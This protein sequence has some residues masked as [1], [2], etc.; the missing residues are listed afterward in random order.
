MS[1]LRN[2]RKNRIV[3][4]MK[5][6]AYKPLL[7][8]ELVTVLDVPA[9]DI[10]DFEEVIKE[11][12]EEGK[13][14]KT[15][16]DRY[17]V[18]ER[19][20]LIT[21]RLQG[22]DRGFGFVIP[23]EEEAGDV[24][25]SGDSLHGAMHNDRV[26]ARINKSNTG[27]KRAEGEV[28]K[29]LKRANTSIVG[30]FESSKYFGFVIPD[31][32]RITSDIFIPKDEINGAKSGEKVVVELIKWPEQRRNAEGRIIEIIG[33]KDDPGN[34]ILSIIK[35]HN[36]AQQ[37][38][39]A[40]LNQAENI[41][42]TVTEDMIKG[43]RD[44]RGLRMVTIDGED[45][46]DLDDAVSVERLP[47]GNYRL[48]VHIADVSYYVTENSP[49]DKEAVKRGTS[50]YL[51][52]RVIPMLPKKLSNG[53]C[54]LNPQVDRLAFS[55][56]MD[57]DKQGRIINH[58]IFESVI[59][60]DE[61]MTYT[62][63][64]KIL[65]EKNP[66]LY[67]RYDYLIS[68]FELM[69][70]L[71]LIL[72]KKRFSRG[73][74]DF[75]F[76][77]A[78]IIL[79]EKGEPIDIKKYEYT[80]ANKIIEEFM[81]ICN[82]TVAEHFYWANAPFVYRIHEEPDIEKI[83]S[84]SDFINK[85]GYHLK[86]S[87]QVHPKAYQDLLSK[88]KGT[89]EERIISTVM[90]RSLQ[91]A[92][93]SHE[94]DGH[95]GLAAKFYCHFTSP[96]RRYPDL[97]IHRIMKEYLRGK[98]NENREDE[99]N[100]RLP[101]IARRCSERERAAEEAERETEDLKKVEYMKQHEGKVFEGI[102]SSVTSFGMF[103]ELDN[104]IEGLVRMSSM[105]DDYYVFDEEQY[106]LFGERNRKIYRIG[107]IVQVQLAKADIAKR[108]LEFVLASDEDNDDFTGYNKSKGNHK[109]GKQRSRDAVENLSEA[110]IAEN[111]HETDDTDSSEK[112]DKRPRKWDKVGHKVRMNIKGRKVR[113]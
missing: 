45:A 76:D 11:L 58:E 36:L 107:D 44:L 79:N 22:S 40:A 78:K 68:N 90:L 96:I 112:K 43:R 91:K 94:S 97:I 47:E 35:A 48:G 80:I 34:D 17:G 59:N 73:A 93:Y 62:N 61:R 106:L 53:I 74:I 8:K 103:I 1:E 87:G 99:L 71:A 13:I 84:F 101:D 7:F 23:D 31:D 108:Q 6:D 57:I 50:V 92:R 30:T 105:E 15:R 27:G 110:V 10:S 72:R 12:E 29:I 67:Q 75:D 95:F 82:E 20:S 54:S 41:S 52:D 3:L 19:M 39:E 100:E 2:E 81:L 32:R 64:Y 37:F 70:E 18:P 98:L 56:F 89:K 14:Y 86:G 33:H 104:T 55:V 60:I 51:V 109:K 111:I 49:L 5:E 24:F 63:V 38:D 25:I 88:V 21:G 42:E 69:K 102:I 65:E 9:S 46:K 113:R 4:F 66:E 16:K 85:L 26:I 83:Q 77:E 28:I